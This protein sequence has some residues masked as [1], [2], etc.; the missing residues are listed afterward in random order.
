MSAR[1][2]SMPGANRLSRFCV[3]ATLVGL[4][5]C[6][7]ES[8]PEARDGGAPHDGGPGALS[9]GGTLDAGTCCGRQGRL[10]VLLQPQRVDFGNVVVNTTATQGLA[11]TNCSG[12][13]VAVTMGAL[14]GTDPL[15]FAS[16]PAPGTVITLKDC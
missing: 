16:T 11:M 14:K 3:L 12:V 15:L 8:V 5:G 4:P 13:D 7:L 6:C 1:A 10:E 9:D 2:T